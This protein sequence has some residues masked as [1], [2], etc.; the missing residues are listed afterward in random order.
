MKNKSITLV[1]ETL[2]LLDYPKQQQDAD[3]VKTAV[4]C[5]SFSLNNKN[6]YHK[7]TV[8]SSLY[9]G[10]QIGYCIHQTIYNCLHYLL[11]TVQLLSIQDA[12][13]EEGRGIYLQD[14]K[15]NRFRA[16]RSN[17]KKSQACTQVIKREVN[18]VGF[19]KLDLHDKIVA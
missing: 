12:D 9:L 3:H 17:Q 7:Q 11:D 13:S 6:S 10:Q 2:E 15:S 16:I 14:L 5:T 1:L 19:G 8:L 18:I 4:V